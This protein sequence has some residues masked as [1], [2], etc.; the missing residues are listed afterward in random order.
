MT[1]YNLHIIEIVIVLILLVIL[2]AGGIGYA[3]KLKASEQLW[4]FA[5]EGA[6]DGVR[7]RQN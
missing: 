2:V 5:L 4:K 3:A 7:G 6:G 1:S